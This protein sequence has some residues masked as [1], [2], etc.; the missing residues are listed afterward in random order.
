MGEFQNSVYTARKLILMLWCESRS[1][2]SRDPYRPIVDPHGHRILG[3]SCG[4]G[5]IWAYFGSAR[6][7]LS[8]QVLWI[9]IH[10]GQLRIR[11][12]TAFLEVL[13]C[14]IHMGRLQMKITVLRKKSYL[15]VYCIIGT[16]CGVSK[17]PRSSS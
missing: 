2:R 1:T 12:D 4:S 10:K 17:G 5:S 15:C 9:R 16:W 8:W 14:R 11:K 13:W 6:T 3:K 7:P